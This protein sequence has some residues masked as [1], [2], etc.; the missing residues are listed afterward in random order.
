MLRRLAHDLL[1][2]Q[3]REVLVHDLDDRPHTGDRGAD[4]RTDDGHL[5][6]R[7]VADALGPELLQH[8]LR[9]AHRAAHLGDVLAHDE[10][11]VVPPHRG[12]HRVANG[13]PVR[14]LGHQE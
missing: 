7:R 6:D 2:R 5:G 4:A 9:H 14:E 12:R 10:D 8:P 1:H 3:R 11:V 13:F